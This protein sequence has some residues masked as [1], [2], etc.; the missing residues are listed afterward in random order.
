MSWKGVI[1][2]AGQTILDQWV[3]GGHVLT[4]TGATVGS[5]Y[6]ADA[7]MRAATALD[8]EED[9]ASIISSEAISDGTRFKIQVGPTDGTAYTAHEIGLWAKLDDGDEVLLA[10]HQDSD[11]G[12]GVPTRTDSP[13]FAFAV[14]L[15][16]SIS[17]SG[18][19][20]VDVDT[21]AYVT[22]S[23]F[24]SEAAKQ[25]SRHLRFVDTTTPSGS[26]DPD[27]NATFNDTFTRLFRQFVVAKASSRQRYDEDTYDTCVVEFETMYGDRFTG[28]CAIKIRAETAFQWARADVKWTLATS[29][30]ADSVSIAFHGSFVCDYNRTTQ[31]TSVNAYIWFRRLVEQDERT[32][33][34]TGSSLCTITSSSVK[35]S[36][37][38]CMIDAVVELNSARPDQ[39]EFNAATVS[40][41]GTAA[42][43]QDAYGIYKGSPSGD[44]GLARIDAGELKII[45]NGSSD[46]SFHVLLQYIAN[47]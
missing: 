45:H 37:K 34:L 38:V 9:D 15:V 1:T 44:V 19:L 29:N 25:D 46:T 41:I 31:V 40:G 35:R 28:T 47:D 12:V 7:S 32:G 17:N 2:N 10:L 21:S 36:G 6:V 39:T 42:S 13:D 22:Q 20:A 5:G 18:D 43:M 4:I 24:A 3:L 16:H 14:Y 33:S 8:S 27:N 11:A 30:S 26:Y 23:T